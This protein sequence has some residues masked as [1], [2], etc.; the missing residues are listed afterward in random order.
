MKKRVVILLL[1]ATMGLSVTGCQSSDTESKDQT[2]ENGRTAGESE[3][4]ADSSLKGTVTLAAAALW[5]MLRS[6]SIGFLMMPFVTWVRRVS[7]GI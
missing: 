5:N 6:A 4:E 7:H 1:A 3:K 2:S